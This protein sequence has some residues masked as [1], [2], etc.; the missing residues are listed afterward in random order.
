MIF[1]TAKRFW[2]ILLISTALFLSLL[3]FVTYKVL[4]DPENTKQVY[5]PMSAKEKGLLHSGDIILR[6]GYGFFSDAIVQSQPEGYAVSHCAMVIRKNN[7]LS[8]VQALSSSV[9]EFDG[10]QGQPLQRFL[11]ESVPNS[12]VVLRFK[13]TP[14]T[15]ELLAQKVLN[16]SRLK[17]PFDHKFDDADTSQFYCT[18]L[19]RQSFLQV[20]KRDIFKNH[21]N[22][23]A[24]NAYDLATFQDTSLFECII[25]HCH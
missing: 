16:Y 7:T 21:R 14:D 23:A 15:L 12:I 18:E 11:N 10:V 2:K 20:L 4:W 1:L 9:A 13:S 17:K 8:V 24:N 3:G 5:Y 6:K 22:A 25:K 19:F